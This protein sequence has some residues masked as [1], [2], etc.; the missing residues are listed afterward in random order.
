MPVA[1]RPTVL[2]ALGRLAARSFLVPA[3]SPVAAMSS[4]TEHVQSHESYGDHYP[5]PVRRYPFHSLDLSLKVR[6]VTDF[7]A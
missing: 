7:A 4:V 5:D 1:R 3:V 6:A 2:L